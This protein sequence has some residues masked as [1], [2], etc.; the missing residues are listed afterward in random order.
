M[1]GRQRKCIFERLQRLLRSICA[2]PN[3]TQVAPGIGIVRVQLQRATEQQFSLRQSSLL[4]SREAEIVQC[5][6]MIGMRFEQLR[7]D[8]RCRVEL[9]LALQ[10]YGFTNFSFVLQVM[11][12]GSYSLGAA[13]DASLIAP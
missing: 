2:N 5:G 4:K 10:S 12:T 3:H 1:L 13:K 7:I 8:R 6:C 9:T 11:L